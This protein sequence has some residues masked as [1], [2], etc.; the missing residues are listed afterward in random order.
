MRHTAESI[1]SDAAQ[2]SGI[3]P[4]VTYDAMDSYHSPEK[5][6]LVEFFFFILMLNDLQHTPNQPGMG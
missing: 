6:G 4:Q 1:I 2:V 5:V 3:F